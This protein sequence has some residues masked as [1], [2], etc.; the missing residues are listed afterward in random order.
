MSL[1]E[2]SINEVGNWE[3][4]GVKNWSKLPTDSTMWEG[5]VKKSE[6][7]PMSFMDG[8]YLRSSVVTFYNFNVF[9]TRITAKKEVYSLPIRLTVLARPY[10]L[11][12]FRNRGLKF[13]LQEHCK[14]SKLS[15]YKAIKWA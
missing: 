6:K 14:F 12:L 5:G 3:G 9:S 4:G 8:P 15:G 2:A 13:M 1:Y 11:Q 7:L 10:S